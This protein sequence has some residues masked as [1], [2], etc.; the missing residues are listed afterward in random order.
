MLVSLDPVLEQLATATHHLGLAAEAIE[1]AERGVDDVRGDVEWRGVQ[2]DPWMLER[3]RALIGVTLV[4][5]AD[6]RRRAR[7]ARECV[8]MCQALA[9]DLE[10]MLELMLDLQP[11]LDP[12][13]IPDPEPAADHPASQSAWRAHAGSLVMTPLL[14]IVVS[15]ALWHWLGTWYSPLV[16]AVLVGYL[17]VTS[18]ASRRPWRRVNRNLLYAAGV[19]ALAAL[20]VLYL[21]GRPRAEVVASTAGYTAAVLVMAVL[22]GRKRPARGGRATGAR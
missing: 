7:D 6:T 16:S 19:V 20:P 17:A 10:L 8:Q 2:Q 13:P 21:I 11:M 1:A 22:Y 18:F 15:E 9:S 14:P 4:S 3:L 12:G 5:L